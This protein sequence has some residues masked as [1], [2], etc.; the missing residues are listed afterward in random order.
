MLARQLSAACHRRAMPLRALLLVHDDGVRIIA[1]AE[2]S[3][4]AR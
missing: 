2:H 1:D 3:V 4:P